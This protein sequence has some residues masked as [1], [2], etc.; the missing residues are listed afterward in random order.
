MIWKAASALHSVNR[1]PLDWSKTDFERMILVA[2]T[3]RN[4]SIYASLR[5][6][7]QERRAERGEVRTSP[8]ARYT[9]AAKPSKAAMINAGTTSIHVATSPTMAS[10]RPR[11]PTQMP[12]PTAGM[13]PLKSQRESCSMELQKSWYL[14]RN[15]WRE[16][17]VPRT[18]AAQR[19]W[20]QRRAVSM[21]FE[22]AMLLSRLVECCVR[23]FFWFLAE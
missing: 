19:S 12:K 18:T 10:S 13:R 5:N 7:P 9:S 21:S 11:A 6:A 4:V 14:G 2:Y 16:T 15:L 23:V 1:L 20:K 22:A 17:E 3:P 8:L